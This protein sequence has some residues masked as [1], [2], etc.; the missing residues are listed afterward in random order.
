MDK[1]HYWFNYLFIT[2]SF[3]GPKVAE[4]L[5]PHVNTDLS[6]FFFMTSRV[7]TLFDVPEVRMTRCGYTG[8]DGFEVGTA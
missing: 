6:D 2:T 4:V 7:V 3:S 1:L 8:E 5:Q